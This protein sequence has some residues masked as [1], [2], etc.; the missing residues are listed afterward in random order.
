MGF[1]QP[2]F[3]GIVYEL[4]V[5]SICKC[6]FEAD[7]KVLGSHQRF[8]DAPNSDCQRRKRNPSDFLSKKSFSEFMKTVRVDLLMMKFKSNYYSF[9]GYFR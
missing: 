9:F 8:R 3:E 4:A 7:A 1:Y 5:C 2:V 6:V